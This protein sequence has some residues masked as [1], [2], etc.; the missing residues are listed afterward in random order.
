M[1]SRI[2][3]RDVQKPKHMDKTKLAKGGQAVRVK[4]TED[5]PTSL[6]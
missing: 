1:E 2:N 5:V 3:L 4:G 6:V